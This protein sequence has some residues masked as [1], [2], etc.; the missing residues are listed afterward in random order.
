M[1]SLCGDQPF[2]GVNDDDGGGDGAGTGVHY[3]EDE[4]GPKGREQDGEQRLSDRDEE[5]NRAGG[6][7]V[8]LT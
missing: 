1:S 3:N 7:T 2:G 8:F 4:P 6:A 5:K